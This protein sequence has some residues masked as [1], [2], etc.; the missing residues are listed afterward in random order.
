MTSIFDI[1]HT[2]L[3][4][5]SLHTELLEACNQNGLLLGKGGAFGNVIRITP[6]LNVTPDEI[7]EGINILNEAI[8]SCN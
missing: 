4:S 2:D 8:L 7:D 1:I 5:L 6:M 3:K